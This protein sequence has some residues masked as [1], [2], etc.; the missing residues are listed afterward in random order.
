MNLNRELPI[1]RYC[2]A[3]HCIVVP[4]RHWDISV[5]VTERRQAKV[6]RITS[7][8]EVIFR[9]TTSECYL[10]N[11]AEDTVAKN[12]TWG[13]NKIQDKRFSRDFFLPPR[14]LGGNVCMFLQ[15]QPLPTKKWIY[16]W[17]LPSHLHWCLLNCTAAQGSHIGVS[18]FGRYLKVRHNEQIWD[19]M[20]FWKCPQKI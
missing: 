15:V 13:L 18:V 17:H 11:G 19:Q 8:M 1:I 7:R 6:A 2:I 4:C 3:K 16:F 5:Q 12:S 20:C 14:S 10:R 9:W